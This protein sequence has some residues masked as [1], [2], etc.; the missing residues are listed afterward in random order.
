MPDEIL[1]AGSV[2]DVAAAEPDGGVRA[3]LTGVANVA[4]VI[5]SRKRRHRFLHRDA[6]RLKA[7]Q[8][9]G[10]SGDATATVTTILVD[11]LARS[12]L[13]DD[14]FGLSWSC[15]LLLVEGIDLVNALGA[16]LVRGGRSGIRVAGRGSSCCCSSNKSFLLLGDGPDRG[17]VL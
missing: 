11:F 17:H 1:H 12:D 7:R 14:G 4:Q 15:L 6:F 13:C 2:E 3:N 16:A 5:L 8:A 10:F 9:S